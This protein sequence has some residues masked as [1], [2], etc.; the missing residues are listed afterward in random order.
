MQ[1]ILEWISNN[2]II[3]ILGTITLVQIVPIKINPWSWIAKGIRKSL[4]VTD[5]SDKFDKLQKD[6]MDEKIDRKRWNILDFG[7]SCMQGRR[8]T[9]E[10][11]D[12]CL[13]DL[14]WYENYCQKHNI[15][16]GVIHE[17]AG[18]LRDKYKELL[19]KNDFL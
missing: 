9:K 11:W 2:L 15:S 6:F 4:G 17:M 14:R 8:H 1:Q 7:N 12:H 10:E 18:F 16:N 5:I 19:I 13:D 3:T